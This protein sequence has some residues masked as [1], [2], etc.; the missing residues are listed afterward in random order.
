MV[1]WGGTENNIYYGT[2]AWYDPVGDT[3]NPMSAINA[4]GARAGHTAVWTGSFMIVWGGYVSNGQTHFN[5]GG[6]YDPAADA[7]TPTSLVNAPSVRRGHVAVWT[8]SLMIVWGGGT[9]LSFP[10]G[11]RLVVS[12]FPDVD[13]DGYPAC[14]ECN[15]TDPL[16]WF[17]P[18]EVTNLSAA[19]SGPTALSWNDQG[20]LVGPG[21][22]YDLVSG[23]LVM[24]APGFASATCL[25]AAG[26]PSYSDTRAGPAPGLGYWYLARGKN[27]CGAGTYGTGP[28]DAGISSCP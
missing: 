11:G 15:D 6:R 10:S 8:G 26:S 13:G 27:S 21:T 12:E 22:T 28:R 25:Q 19:G 7:W 14:A 20:A 5:T 24:G 3:W 23:T 16:A 4:P 9:N 2:G 1:V 17:S 18:V